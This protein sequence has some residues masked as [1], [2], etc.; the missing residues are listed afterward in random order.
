MA[1]EASKL[2][3]R[4]LT[5]SK[6]K[7]KRYKDPARKQIMNHPENQILDRDEIHTDSL[8]TVTSFCP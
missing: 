6:W 7:Y 3:T 4:N 8:I 2:V 5:D 1:T